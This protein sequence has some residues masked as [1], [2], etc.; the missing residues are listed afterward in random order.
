MKQP[1]WPTQSLPAFKS[2]L[3]SDIFSSPR[4]S[5]WWAGI[6]QYTYYIKLLYNI[7]IL[8]WTLVSQIHYVSP[9][10]QWPLMFQPQLLPQVLLVRLNIGLPDLPQQ[11]M[12]GRWGS[13]GAHP[14]V[15]RWFISP[16]LMQTKNKSVLMGCFFV[17]ISG[18]V[19]WYSCLCARG[20]GPHDLLTFGFFKCD[21]TSEEMTH[22][23]KFRIKTH[24]RKTRLPKKLLVS[25]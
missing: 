6:T 10:E 14:L 2:M 21:G 8:I 25:K 23:L 20:C 15:N 1:Y 17:T 13:P 9:S 4:K 16:R 3:A 18:E 24:N 5:Y 7:Q 22:L 12:G 19:T 11:G